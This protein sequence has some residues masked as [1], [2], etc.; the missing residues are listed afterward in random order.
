MKL[1]IIQL[2]RIIPSRAFSFI[3]NEFIVQAKLAFR[4]AGEVSSHHDLSIDICS[5]NSAFG[6][7]E[8]VDVL[9]DVDEGFVFAVFDV[10]ASPAG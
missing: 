5:E 2:D 3:Q 8:Q 4:C 1:T 10:V 9:H 6:A 7:H